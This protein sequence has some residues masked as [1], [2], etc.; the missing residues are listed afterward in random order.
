[1][2]VTGQHREMLDQVNGL[3]GIV[4]HHDLDVFQAGQTLNMLS[5]KVLWGMDI[6]L[7]ELA[8]DAVVVQG[9]TTTVAMASVAAFNRAVPLVHL[10]AGLRS[11][12]MSDP[13]PEEGNRKIVTQVAAL[14]LTPT[15]SAR[16]NLT[17]EQR[18]EGGQRRAGI[19]AAQPQHQ[20]AD[21]GG[22]AEQEEPEPPTADE[23]DQGQVGHASGDQHRAAPQTRHG[24][25]LQTTTGRAHARVAL[26]P[27]G[28]PDSA[29]G[30]ASR[31]D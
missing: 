27:R 11:G 28:A 3:F 29:E 21:Q 18:G 4:P 13:F 25:L 16:T 30:Q 19:R 10:E 15:S 20:R 31:R 14:H 6:A 5:A 26:T 17:A 1:M 12:S 22:E 7:T 9:D 24:V 23:D 8:P 2:V